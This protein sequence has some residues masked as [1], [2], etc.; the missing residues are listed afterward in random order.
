[1]SKDAAQSRLL[2]ELG[3]GGCS[4]VLSRGEASRRQRGGSHRSSR[5]LRLSLL[6]QARL[7]RQQVSRGMKATSRP[8]NESTIRIDGRWR[9][10]SRQLA[11]LRSAQPDA[12]VL[13]GPDFCAGAVLSRNRVCCAVVLRLVG[14]P[15]AARPV[16]RARRATVLPHGS[17]RRVRGVPRRRHD[18]RSD[19][20]SPLL[21]GRGSVSCL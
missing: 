20:A 21:Q 18:P 3:D 9:F 4:G 17:R 8:S 13:H 16:G 2:G 11:M 1:V 6:R 5:C 15:S 10:C 12:I 7:S 14:N 19:D